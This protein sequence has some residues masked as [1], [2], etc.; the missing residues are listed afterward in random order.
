M[1]LADAPLVNCSTLLELKNLL[2]NAAM[3]GDQAVIQS[4]HH[5]SM[6]KG[7]ADAMVTRSSPR[8]SDG[9]V[10]SSSKK[11]GVENITS[12][13]QTESDKAG[14]ANATPTSLETLSLRKGKGGK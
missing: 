9:I 7:D 6:S 8:C 4:Q 14:G 13:S 11:P 10:S 2:Q 5:S 1:R 12:G 3:S